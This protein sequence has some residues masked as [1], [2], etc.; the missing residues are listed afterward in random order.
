MVEETKKKASLKNKSTTTKLNRSAP[1]WKE[2]CSWVELNIFNYTDKQKLQRNACLVLD[3][4]RKG[5]NVANNKAETYG[6]YPIEVILI[7]F[8]AYKAQIVKAIQNKDFESE[9]NKMKYVCAVIRDKLNDVFTRYLNAKKS[10]EKI[11]TVNTD[12]MEYQGV[13]YKAKTD[14]ENNKKIEEKFGDLW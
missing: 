3:G 10:E 12:I 6:E 2:L 8:K 7:A 5:Q 11:E 9:E 13:E 1:E 14:T 4:L